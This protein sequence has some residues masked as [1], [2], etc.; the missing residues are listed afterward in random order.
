MKMA[1][2]TARQGTATEVSP[3]EDPRKIL[4]PHTC[5]TD[6]SYIAI[7]LARNILQ[8]TW[9]QDGLRHVTPQ[10]DKSSHDGGMCMAIRGPIACIS[11]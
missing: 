4:I 5:L 2:A 10:A 11:V 8:W 3:F 9:H 1:S 6:E 7:K